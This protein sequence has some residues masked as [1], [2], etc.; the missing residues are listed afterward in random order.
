MTNFENTAELN[1]DTALFS[2]VETYFKFL[3][4]RAFVA[5]YQQLNSIKT[6]IDRFFFCFVRNTITFYINLKKHFKNRKIIE[7]FVAFLICRLG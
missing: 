1:A 7:S 4:P 6:I 2:N 3:W 5:P